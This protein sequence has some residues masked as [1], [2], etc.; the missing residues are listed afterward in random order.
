ML[1]T[2]AKPIYRAG[3][4]L[5]PTVD[6]T[7]ALQVESEHFIDCIRHGTQPITTGAEYIAVVRML[8]AAEQSILSGGAFVPL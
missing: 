1:W 3:D 6:R 5:I 7:E 2:T 4:V 8:E